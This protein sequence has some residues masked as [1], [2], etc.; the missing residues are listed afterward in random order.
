MNQTWVL[1][2]RG[3]GA[4]VAEKFAAEGCNI[5]INYVSNSERAEQTAKKIE[6]EYKAKTV[7]VQGVRPYVPS[8]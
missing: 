4:L 6:K 2:C 7:I 3:L 1:H 5:A 8:I